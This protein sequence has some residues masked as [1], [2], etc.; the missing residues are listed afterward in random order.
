[1]TE[2]GGGSGLSDSEKDLF[3]RFKVGEKNAHRQMNSWAR[4]FV[5]YRPFG[6]PRSEHD[7]IVQQ[8]VTQLWRCCCRPDFTVRFGLRALLRR[9]VFARCI[10]YM[11]RPHSDIGLDEATELPGP[12]DSAL[13]DS[14]RWSKVR[15]AIRG[16]GERCRDIIRM[17][18]LE[19]QSYAVIGQHMGIATATVRVHMFHCLREVRRRLEMDGESGDT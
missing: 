4:D 15:W 18:F 2:T 17:H 14:D 11:R 12:P 8:S 19:D 13:L 16:L 5:R 3:Q 1:M 9:I 7:D 10:D 6:V